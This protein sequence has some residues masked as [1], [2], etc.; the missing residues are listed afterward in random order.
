MRAGIG[1]SPAKGLDLDKSAFAVADL[2]APDSG[3]EDAGRDNAY[4][5]G[6]GRC[7]TASSRLAGASRERKSKACC[8]GQEPGPTESRPE[9]QVQIQ[10]Q[11]GGK[12]AGDRIAESVA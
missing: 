8:G 7:R 11:E 10:E 1:V 5:R 4:C 6:L 2:Q 9:A 12:G 3:M